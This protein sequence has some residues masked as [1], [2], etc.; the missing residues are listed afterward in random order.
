MDRKFFT[1]VAVVVVTI[2]LSGYVV[3]TK[4]IQAGLDLQGGSHLTFSPDFSNIPENQRADAIEKTLEV[5]RNRIDAIGVA[6][7]IVQQQGADTISV[8]VPGIGTDESKRI[9]TILLKQAHLQFRLVE[10][11]PGEPIIVN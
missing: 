3:M 5:F 7:T 6:G 9:K 8:Q 10:E 1:R 11:G 2:L 4:P